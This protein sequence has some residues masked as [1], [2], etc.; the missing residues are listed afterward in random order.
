MR[1]EVLWSQGRFDEARA[2]LVDEQQRL[3]RAL[4]HERTTRWEHVQL[5]VSHRATEAISEADPLTGPAEPALPRPLAAA[6]C[7]TS[8]SPC[9]SR[10]S[11][12]TAS[13][14]STTSWS[15]AHGDVV[16]QEL[17][18]ILQRVCRRGDAVVRLG[19][20]EFVIVLRD[21][22]PNDGRTVL[23][24][25]RQLI[26]ARRWPGLPDSLVLTASVGVS[27]GSGATEAPRLLTA[28]SEALQTAKRQG[29]DRIVFA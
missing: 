14:R 23:E 3:E 22:S 15:Y 29:R 8:R 27:V 19:G 2:L 7:S 16:L 26:A 20:D 17:A 13:S 1:V 21:T 11:T 25:L 6:R 10:C 18:T 28:A 9:A 24:R 12:S 5:G 4:R